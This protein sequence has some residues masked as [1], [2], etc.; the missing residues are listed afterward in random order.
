M[1]TGQGRS[2]QMA[3]RLYQT[4]QAFRREFDRCAAAVAAAGLDVPLTE[5]VFLDPARR[6][7]QTTRSRRRSQWTIVSAACG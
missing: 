5:L 7:T 6:L 4:D 1:F 2:M 3:R